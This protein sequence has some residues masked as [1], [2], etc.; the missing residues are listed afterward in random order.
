[1]VSVEGSTMEPDTKTHRKAISPDARENQL[2]GL[3]YDTA[4]ERMRNGTASSQEIVHFL[5]LG[6]SLVRLQKKEIE[7]RILLDKQKIK[8]MESQEEI[9]QLYEG[10]IEAIRSYGGDVYEP[11]ARYEH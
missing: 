7:E 10:A 4:E 1:M 2:I 6:S 3:A 9:K 5:K 11:G 8:T